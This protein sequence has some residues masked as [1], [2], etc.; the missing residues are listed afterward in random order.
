VG[1]NGTELEESVMA[2][3]NAAV[4]ALAKASKGLLFPSETDAPLGP[5]LWENAGDKLSKDKVRQQAGA[6]KGRPS[7]RGPW[8]TCSPRCPRR[9]G[10]SST[11]WPPPSNSSCRG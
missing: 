9:T 1:R 7:R 11:N 2:K 4:D 6:A 8:T 5:L 10:R 3:K